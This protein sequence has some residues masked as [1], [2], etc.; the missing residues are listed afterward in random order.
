MKTTTCKKCGQPD[1]IW[2]KSKKGKWYLGTDE[3]LAGE[4]RP[5]KARFVR[6]HN[7][8]QFAENDEAETRAFLRP[9]VTNE[10]FGAYMDEIKQGKAQLTPELFTAINI[11]VEEE[12]DRRIAAAAIADK[13]ET[14]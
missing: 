13:G 14:K 12:I 1:L 7:C 2:A 4:Y 8:E 3:A 11:E 6:A 5:V 9:I 10:I